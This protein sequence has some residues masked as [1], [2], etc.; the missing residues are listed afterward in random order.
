MCKE[1]SIL[2]KETEEWTECAASQK[3][4][5]LRKKCRKHTLSSFQMTKTTHNSESIFAVRIER[6]KKTKNELLFLKEL[7]CFLGG[8]GSY[9]DSLVNFDNEHLKAYHF[10]NVK[11][12]KM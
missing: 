7:Y 10:C 8:Y 11:N 2:I 9:S 4:R 3:K 6:V 12:F 5:L 1:Q